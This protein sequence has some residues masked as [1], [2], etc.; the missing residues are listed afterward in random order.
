MPDDRERPQ[1]PDIGAERSASGPP[2]AP[3]RQG[4]RIVRMAWTEGGGLFVEY[5]SLTRDAEERG[6]TAEEVLEELIARYPERQVRDLGRPWV[7]GIV[8][9]EPPLPPWLL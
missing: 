2:T 6:R 4:G 3:A 9:G 8:A 7:T 1:T 5:R